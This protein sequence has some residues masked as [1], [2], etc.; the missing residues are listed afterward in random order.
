MFLEDLL[1]L[2]DVH[3]CAHV[4]AST[5]GVQRR[6]LHIGSPG[7][8]V[9]SSCQSPHVLETDHWPSARAILALIAEPF[10]QLSARSPF[11]GISVWG[12]SFCLFQAVL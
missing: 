8:G 2:N 4:C 7:V 5:V 1:F 6:A 10:L 11:M 9:T 12:D 3:E